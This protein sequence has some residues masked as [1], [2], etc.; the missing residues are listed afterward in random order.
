MQDD[1]STIHHRQAEKVKNQEESR[2]NFCAVNLYIKY[3]LIIIAPK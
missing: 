3:L 2:V 1:F